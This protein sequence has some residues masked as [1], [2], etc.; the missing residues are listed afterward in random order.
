MQL[1]LTRTYIEM[2]LREEN[3]S[4]EAIMQLYYE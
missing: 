3:I 4:S 2:A 1:Q